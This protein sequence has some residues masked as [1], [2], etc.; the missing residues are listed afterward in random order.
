MRAHPAL[1]VALALGIVGIRTARATPASMIRCREYGSSGPAVLVLHGG[2]GAMGYMAP[3][4]RGL[5]D[6]FRVLE[7]W[8]RRSGGAPLT[9]ARHI[10]DLHELLADEPE[11]PAL[12]GHSWGAML[13]LAYAATHPGRV[14]GLVLVGCG[15][16]DGEARARLHAAL[17]ERMSDAL[18]RRLE[19]LE[20]DVPDTDTRLRRLGD[21]LLPLYSYDSVV[22][23]LAV[24]AAD[25]RAHEETWA[26]M[27]RLQ[28]EGVYP[29][30]L[31]AIEA[32]VLMLHGAAD[33]H[34]GPLIR[35]SLAPYLAQ[36]EYRE[37]EL[38][39]HYPW[40]EKAVREEFF[41]VLR[42]RLAR[43]L[44]PVPSRL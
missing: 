25:A 24:E 12:V 29:A 2:P 40:L 35:A 17:E 10:T 3:V 18:R 38:C 41:D 20:D 14:A 31:A 7:P 9:V 34:P 15:T 36:L 21:L 5:S 39:G 33:P 23:T 28:K 44:S 6:R 37:W 16:F 4:A 22:D 11:R 13:A 19:R 26:D 32:P 42:E 43:L 8:Q 27:I 1:L 30:A